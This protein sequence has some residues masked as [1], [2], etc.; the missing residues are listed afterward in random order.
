MK[1][2]RPA[3]SLEIAVAVIRRDERVLVA[4]RPEGSH[5][6]GQWEF[7]GGKVRQGEAHV[8]ALDREIEEEVGVS[9]D[10]PRLL[11][12]EEHRYPGR[13]VRLNF[14]LCALTAD[15]PEPE[16]AEGQ[17]IRW[18][19]ADELRELPTPAANRRVIEM[20]CDQLGDS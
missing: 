6:E 10:R 18:V 14:F 4:R 17:E 1:K 12:R 8:D 11:H 19:R 7:P 16:G 9:I 20:I 13:A 2:D 5:L 3:A 15:T